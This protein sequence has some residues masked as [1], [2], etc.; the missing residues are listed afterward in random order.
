MV[1]TGKPP[2]TDLV[3]GGD[4]LEMVRKIDTVIWT[5]PE[6]HVEARSHKHQTARRPDRQKYYARCGNLNP[7][8]RWRRRLWK[9]GE[10]ELDI[11]TP[12]R[13]DSVTGKGILATD[14]RDV[15]WQ[16]GVH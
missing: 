6:H 1:G 3:R 4:A 9:S 13:F 14:S 10:S 8:T 12:S 5:K 7:N 2:R 11:P 15:D 16:P